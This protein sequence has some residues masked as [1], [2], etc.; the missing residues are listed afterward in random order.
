M[1]ANII[2]DSYEWMPIRQFIQTLP[3]F[4][5]TDLQGALD[6]FSGDGIALTVSPGAEGLLIGLVIQNAGKTQDAEQVFS[7]LISTLADMGNEVNISEGEYRNIHYH[8]V[9]LKEQEISY[10]TVGDF[11]SYRQPLQ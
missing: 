1:A 5:G 8:T 4:L 2:T 10:G 9:Q 6:T 3:T 11:F 7:K